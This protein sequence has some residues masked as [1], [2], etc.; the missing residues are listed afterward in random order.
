MTNPLYI[1]WRGRR[2]GPHSAPE[3]QGM[4]KRRELS[5]YHIIIDGDNK[6]SLRK[7]QEL[8]RL[9]SARQIEAKKTPTAPPPTMP[10][11]P[12]A[13]DSETD[14]AGESRQN[15]RLVAAHGAQVQ[16]DHYYL[17]VDE[18]I[19][20]PFP[21]GNLLADY[22]AGVI[23]VDAE[24]RSENE[25]RWWPLSERFDQNTNNHR[26]N[27]GLNNDLEFHRK[28]EPER[29][30]RI[31]YILLGLFLGGF[32]I[33]NFYA[34]YTGRGLGQLLGFVFLVLVDYRMTFL[35]GIWALI[36]IL[37]VNRD[38]QGRRMI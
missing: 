33:H 20:G 13:S 1:E 31:A 23:S 5:S 15:A 25:K 3:L 7:W 29:K 38:P 28:D 6:L 37:S 8:Q 12:S 18:H 30:Y 14:C 26:R 32:G 10:P 11:V 4:V 22:K 34:G 21:L 35:I 17:K 9:E 16:N 36:E 27:P 24:Y 2:T 19:T